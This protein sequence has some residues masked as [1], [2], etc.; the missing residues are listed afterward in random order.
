[1]SAGQA[2]EMA[3]SVSLSPET[4]TVESSACLSARYISKEADRINLEIYDY[5]FMARSKSGRKTE[6]HNVVSVNVCVCVT[7]F[8]SQTV[9][10]P[11]QHM[12]HMQG[13]NI[14]AER[15]M[16][17]YSRPARSV[18]VPLNLITN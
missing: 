8:L 13:Q 5:V 4:N 11:I 9:F 18:L 6:M 3:G 10:R 14:F 12:Q 17:R 16:A 1:M 7:V 2:D 15:T